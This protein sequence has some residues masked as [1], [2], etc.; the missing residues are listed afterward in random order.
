MELDLADR[1]VVVTGGAS[2]IGRGIVHAFAAEGGRIVLCD[3]DAEQA[4]RVA[5]EARAHGAAE[6]VVAVEDLGEEGAGRRVVG[7][8]VEAFG[9]VDILVNN[10]GISVPGFFNEQ[11]DRSMWQRTMDVNV[12]AAIECTQAVLE[13]MAEVQEGSVV[14]ISSDAAFGVIRQGVYGSSKA[15]MIAMA[16][17]VAREQGRN[18]IRSNVVCPGLVLPEGDE[19][20]GSTSLWAGDATKIW[21]ED[22]IDYMRKGTPLKRLTTAADVANAVV[23][24]SSPTAARQVT[25][26]VVAVGGGS[27]MP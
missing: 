19:A 11:T 12:F 20:I 2:N 17:T 23:W 21:S 10:A 18:G 1:R 27:A 15:A 22:Q 4:Q 5:D 6:V 26:Q 13:P 8:A 14:F 16:R 9:G 7:R 24:V 25:G 3:L